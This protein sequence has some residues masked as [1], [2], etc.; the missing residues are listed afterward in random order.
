MDS[1]RRSRFIGKPSMRSLPVIGI[2]ICI[3]IGIG[4]DRPPCSVVIPAQAGIQSSSR[5]GM[6]SRL[7]GNDGEA[8]AYGLA[9]ENRLSA[10]GRIHIII[11]G[12]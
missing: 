2:W 11:Y 7:R 8:G 4:I 12:A 1:R 5:K 6:N 3:C 10:S 9:E